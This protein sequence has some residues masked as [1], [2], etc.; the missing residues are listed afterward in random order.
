MQVS[1]RSDRGKIIV[2][3]TD[4]IAKVNFEYCPRP[5]FAYFAFH[6]IF[7]LNLKYNVIRIECE[8]Q[9]VSIL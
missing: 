4:S 6:L 7:P 2:P 8:S 1:V 3:V 5:S 9:F